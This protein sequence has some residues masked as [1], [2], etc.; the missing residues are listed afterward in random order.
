VAEKRKS[1]AE[2]EA[3]RGFAIK[4]LI[5]T[6]SFDLAA[7]AFR[8]A[9]WAGLLYMGVVLPLKLTAGKQMIVNFVYGAALDLKLHMVVPWAAAAL[10]GGLWQWER[11]LRKKTVAREHD[12]VVE[13]EKRLD[14]GRTSSGLTPMGDDP[15]SG[16]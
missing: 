13:L 1:K 15:G 3:G 10:F 16:P 4:F 6:R 9:G 2:K 7:I 8:F 11:H 5:I 14:P 12:R